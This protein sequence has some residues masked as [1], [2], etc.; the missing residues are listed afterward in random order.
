VDGV[1]LDPR[2]RIGYQQTLPRSGAATSAE[3]DMDVSLRSTSYF[4]SVRHG[5]I[6]RVDFQRLKLLEA[7]ASQGRDD[8]RF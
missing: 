6:E 2:H 8:V 7:M 5:P 4:P 3:H 1:L